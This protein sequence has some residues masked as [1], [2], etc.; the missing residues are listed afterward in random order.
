MPVVAQAKQAFTARFDA[1]PTA[2]VRA[3][4]RINFSSALIGEHTDY[5]DG[6]KLPMAIDRAVY[7]Q[8]PPLPCGRDPTTGSTSTPSTSAY[9]QRRAECE[10]AVCKL[11]AAYPGHGAARCDPGDVGC[12]S[13]SL[14]A[15]RVAA[16]PAHRLR[17]R[18]LAG[19]SRRW[20]KATCSVWVH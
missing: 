15:K 2:L 13:R 1:A 14:G 6:R 3:A 11:Q 4:G 9:N 17:K 5:N 12:R 16:R 19:E 8:Q 18:A 10:A 20:R 7:G